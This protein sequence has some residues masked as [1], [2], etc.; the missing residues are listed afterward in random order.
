MK[1]RDVLT[2]GL[3]C[4]T[5][6]VLAPHPTFAQSKYPDRPIKLVVPFAPGGAADVI[7][8]MWA[9]AMKAR[10]GPVFLENQSGASGIIGA[11]SVARSQ[12][13]GFTLML[14]AGGPIF[15]AGGVRAPYDPIKDF[16]PVTILGTT[17]LAIMVHPSMPAQNLKELV[18]YAKANHGKL[19]YG[20]AGVGTMTHLA[21]ALLSSLTGADIVH[22]AY[23]GGG[24]FAADLLGGSLPMGMMNLTSQVVD[25]HRGGKLRMLATT[26]PDR[27]AATPEI[28]TAAEQGLPGMIA[29]NFF[30]LFAPA[31]TSEAVVARISDA[32]HRA[33]IDHGFRERLL[34]AGYE[35]YPDL[36]PEAARRFVREEAAKWTPI[37]EAAGA[38]PE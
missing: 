33:M 17:A 37:V 23:K 28:P 1:R 2:L 12:P 20:S 35:P 3:G 25:L 36:S 34:A 18:E 9:D 6:G 16:A 11:A 26:G 29:R 21:G 31:G 10:L 32:T 38:K 7:G 5:A 15:L 30:G 13:D 4:L 8:R 22:V 14:T 27:D 19:S 24:Q